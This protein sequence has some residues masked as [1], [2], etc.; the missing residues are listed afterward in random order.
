MARMGTNNFVVVANRLPV[1]RVTDPDGET[2]WRRSP[3]GLVTALAPVMRSYDGAWVG[4][5]G[6]PDDELEPFA[7]DGMDLV[8]VALSAEEISEFYEGFSNATLWPLYHDVIVP[9]VYER[10]WWDAYRRVNNRFARATAAIADEGAVVFIQ[11]Y[12]LQ[13]VPRILRQLRPDLKIG[14]FLHIPFPPAELFAQLPW[15][16]QICPDCWARTW[17]DSSGVGRWATSSACAPGTP[18]PWRATICWSPTTGARSACER[19]RY[20]STSAK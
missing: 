5:T 17:W 15:R 18:T 3:G 11:D 20:P 19:S 10:P 13:L 14:F 1:D 4:W 7:S 6:V 12:Q 9:P 16:R 8:P 2:T